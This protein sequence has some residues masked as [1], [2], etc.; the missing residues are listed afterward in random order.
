MNE[1]VLKRVEEI[2][3][4]VLENL[5]FHLID[6]EFLT[7]HGRN[8]LRFYI[9]NDEGKI[10]VGECERASRAI[11]DLLAVE[12]V[13]EARYDLE[14]GSPG[15]D[16]PLKTEKDFKEH[17]GDEIRVKTREPF[18]ERSHY[19]GVLEDFRDGQI[20]IIIDGTKFE[21]PIDLVSKARLVPNFE[22]M[23]GKKQ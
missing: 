2:I 23:K 10:T 5:G 9:D 6:V 18:N 4:P 19:K 17:V 16:R 15:L 21:I 11:E 8:V 14:V 13:V 12:N 22:K 1:S 7:E 3:L 20:H